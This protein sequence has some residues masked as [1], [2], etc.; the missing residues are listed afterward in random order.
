MKKNNVWKDYPWGKPY[1]FL[2]IMKLTFILTLLFVFNVRANTYSQGA[3]LNISV[4]QATLRELFDQIKS[5]SDYKFLYNNDLVNDELRINVNTKKGS[6][7][8]VLT[9]ALK[10]SNLSFKVVGKQILIYPLAEK[11][12]PG[13]QAQKNLVRGVVTDPSGAPLPGATVTISGSTRGVITDA[14]GNY[15][16]EA[17]RGEKLVFSFIGMESETVEVVTQKVVNVQMREKS[18]ELED[19]TVVAFGRQKKESVVASISTVDV[20]ELRVPAS[21]LTTALAGK[22]AGI[23][24]YQTSG[25]PGADNAQFFVRGVTTFGY[26]TS[27]L[28]LIDGFESTTDDL[29][30]LQPDDIESFSVMKDASATVMYGARSANGIISVVTKAGREGSV[31]ISVRGDM[32][33]AMPTRKLEFLD[34]VRYM[35]LYNEAQITRN[36]LLGAYYDEQKI[37]ATMRGEYPMIYPNVYWY[38]ALFNKSTVNEK[39]NLNISGGGKVA[40]YYVSGTMEHETGLLKVDRRNNF[41][42]NIDITRTNIRSNVIFRL[43]PSTTLDTRITG[44]FE[45]YTGPYETASEIYR[46]IMWSNPVD[47]PFTYEPDEANKYTEHVL[48]GSTLIGGSYKVNP[49]ASMVRGYE[50]RNETSITAQATLTQDLDFITKGLKISLKASANSW[51]KY[52]SRRTYSPYYYALENYNQITGEYSLFALNPTTGQAYLGDVQP[53]R[54]ASGQYYYEGILNWNRDF[55]KHKVGFTSVAIAQENLVTGGNSSSIYFTLPEKNLGVSGRVTYDYDTRYFLDFSYGYNG[56]EK[57]SGSKQFGF[58][59]ALAAGW[60][61]S[62]ESFFEPYKNM[63]SALKLKFSWGQGGNDAISGREGRFFFLSNVRIGGGSYRW[64]N[65]FMNA[66]DGYTVSRYANPNITWEVSTK[67]NAGLELSLFKNESLRFQI[68]FF[69]DSRDKIYMVRENFPASAGLEASISGNVG[70][71]DSH[72]IDASLDIE[73]Q[74]NK[75]FWLTG[76]GNFTYS[77]N[78]YVELDEK[79][80]P[81]EYLK[82]KGHNINQGWGL[83]GERLFVDQAE[84]DNSPRQDFGEY[85]AGDIKYKDVNGDGVVNSNDRVPMGY[86][87]SPEIQIGAGLSVGYKKF[88]LSFFFQ[89]NARVSM[90]INPGVGGGDDGAEGI[91]PLVNNRN[92]MPFIADDYWSETNPNPYAFWPRLSTTTVN[93]NL[94]QSSWWLRDVSFIRLKSAELG[95]NFPVKKLKME[96]CRF[97]VTGENLLVFS[98]FKYWDPEMGRKGIGYPPNRRFNIGVKLDF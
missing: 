68:D 37:Q 65:T 94:Q 66:Y 29:A 54:D 57:F 87:T 12:N 48:F 75:D 11:E 96:N 91:A 50:D 30:R 47:F 58:F 24:S 10:Q 8:D 56:S 64:G 33:V 85:M 81:D 86:P 82:R 25:E 74:F 13:I 4:Q 84:I 61:V 69:K 14:D 72:G 1:T 46:Q 34:G 35:R 52:T 17:N 7:E 51:G 95:Y 16:I 38:D 89:G 36:P 49:Y 15:S 77:T 90:F 45:R 31:K 41:N 59:P 6:V 43:S 60:L 71:V 92:A 79:N 44:R 27:P 67:Y 93:N 5:Q 18:Q 97:Y 78:E 73:H 32:N 28:I 40:T 80:Y 3:K 63:I 22:I 53:G 2:L 88:D 23:I 9:E 42:N 55:G 19:V 70:K 20:A 98:K 26:K 62:N 21:N 76:R 83:I 39:V